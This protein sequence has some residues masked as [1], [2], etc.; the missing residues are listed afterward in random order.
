[1]LSGLLGSTQENRYRLDLIQKNL[2]KGAGIPELLP[3]VIR[4]TLNRLSVLGK[5]KRVDEKSSKSYFLT[6]K[7]GAEL[8]RALEQ[9]IDLFD[10]VLRRMLR[11]TEHQ[12]PSETGKSICRAFILECFSRFGQQIARLVLGDY[13]ADDLLRMLDVDG[14]FDSVAGNRK[15]S[16]EARDSLFN[17]CRQFLRSSEDEDKRLKLHLTQWFYFMELLGL[18]SNGS[19]FDPLAKQAFRGSVFYLDTNVILMGLLVSDNRLKMFRE[20]MRMSARLGVELRVTRATINETRHVI[21]KRLTELNKYLTRVPAELSE[22]T[23]DQFLAGYLEARAREPEL[24]PE[25]FL[26]PFERLE[27]TIKDDWKIVIR[28]LSEDEMLAGRKLEHETAIVQ[29]EAE[30]QRP[31]PKPPSVL[32]HD[33]SHLALVADERGE[34]PKTWFL[35]DDT[36]LV[37]AASR[38]ASTD[39]KQPLAAVVGGEP[40]ETLATRVLP[41]C[42][43]LASF[44]Q[45]IS[46]FTVSPEE[47]ASL[48][49][50]FSTLLN[51]RLAISGKLFDMREMRILVEWNNDVMMTPPEQ[52][53]PA[54]DHVKKLVL[55]G[56][57]YKNGDMPRVALELKKYLSKS[58]EERERALEEEVR[59][60]TEETG[61]EKRARAEVERKAAELNEKVT[62]FESR[63]LAQAAEMATI[64]EEL[65]L[66]KQLLEEGERQQRAGYILRRRYFMLAG[67]IIGICVWL[68]TDDLVR[69]LRARGLNFEDRTARVAITLLGILIFCLPALLYTRSVAW[70][71]DAKVFFLAV[72]S[73]SVILASLSFFDNAVVSTCASI[74]EIAMFSATLLYFAVFSRSSKQE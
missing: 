22:L 69:M 47:E 18:G 48:A 8:D 54:L 36:S 5:V 71:N 10:P 17:R 64:Q 33:V 73:V 63:M 2:R 65:T 6:D 23:H 57:P 61:Q 50:I 15:L 51:E 39:K 31:Y 46:P 3:E 62:E 38:L 35:T 27:E 25:Q 52:L 13:D 11:D 40:R 21:A 59:R 7:G 24:T 20:M 67:F 58:V 68:L 44:L 28:E 56:R 16:S 1:V 72:L 41:F 37:R 12:V 26:K 55:E 66:Q 9:A 42:F 19:P 53:A 70:R 45:S 32:R 29:Q 60:R 34:N 4:D 43:Y 30:S 74:I 14:V 49:D